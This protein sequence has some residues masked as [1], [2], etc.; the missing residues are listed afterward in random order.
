[1][2]VSCPPDFFNDALESIDGSSK[3]MSKSK[4]DEPWLDAI[5][6]IASEYAPK[7]IS[8]RR[9][10]HK[11]P[12]LSG[13][14]LATTRCLAENAETLGLTPQV[15]GHGRGLI[16]DF[17]SSP[18]LADAPRL[19]FRGDI[20][21]LPIEDAKSVEY[22]SRNEGIMHACGH[23]AH[24]SIV[25]AAIEILKTLDQR[26]QLPWP[27]A[28][29]A[30]FQPSE[31]TA[32]GARYMIHHHALANV[33]AILSLHVDPTRAV[34][35]IGLRPGILTAACDIVEVEFTGRG[36]HG[37][38]PHLCHDPIDASTLWVQSVFRLISRISSPTDSIVFSVGRIESGQNANVIPGK[39]SLSGSL[40]SLD[41]E[42]RST[43]LE[44]LESVCE[45]VRHQTGCRAELRLGMSSPAVE[46]DETL[47]RLLHDA[48]VRVLSPTAPE[49]IPE[50]SMGSEDFSF[51]LEH[52]PGAM[53]R[54]GIAGQQIGHAPLHTPGFD[55]DETAI[56]VGA[57]LLAAAAID[58][59]APRE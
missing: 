23:D 48:S 58:F 6:E 39:A 47:I 32:E 13:Y 56:T 30:L 36:G 5:T 33:K 40:R 52:V 17:V 7:W 35:H 45:S 22:R 31:E 20:D 27:V 18:A 28:V 11:F 26:G 34:G 9:H 1:M 19:A 44:M 49:S 54:L 51:Y 16:T 55:V 53:F 2:I 42:V 8:L 29:R 4:T 59:F 24:A 37:A 50:P 46:N 10:L 57:K 15:V 3:R 21:A 12:E 43:A 14:E 25:T 41:T 38:R